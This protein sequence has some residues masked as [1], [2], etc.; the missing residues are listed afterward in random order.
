MVIAKYVVKKNKT[1]TKTKL[2]KELLKHFNMTPKEKAKDLVNKYYRIIPL[3]KMTIDY[4][5]AK[6]CALI[7]I[8][9]IMKAGIHTLDLLYWEEVK[10]EIKN[11]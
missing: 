3:D 8:D 9:E 7:A 1:N 6:Q 4:N 5:L 2:K 10:Q 11:L